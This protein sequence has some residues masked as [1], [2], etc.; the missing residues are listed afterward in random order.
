MSQHNYESLFPIYQASLYADVDQAI[1]QAGL[2]SWLAEFTPRQDR[3]FLFTTHPNMN[4]IQS[5]MKLANQHSG[6]SFAVTMRAM[7]YIAKKGWDNWVA[8]VKFRR[9]YD[10]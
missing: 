8:E 5:H 3:G 9:K 7:E 1:T 2:W 6:S 4:V 10:D